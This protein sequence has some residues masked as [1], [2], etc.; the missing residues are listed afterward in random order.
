MGKQAKYL[1]VSDDIKRSFDRLL[2][3]EYDFSLA[4]GK[5]I[6]M[7][8]FFQPLI[9]LTDILNHYGGEQI[10]FKEQIDIHRNIIRSNQHMN[11][12]FSRSMREKL[13]K[14]LTNRNT[15]FSRRASEC[16]VVDC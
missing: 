1:E 16:L 15:V 2:E 3:I 8:I 10:I 5:Y 7:D 14:F 12:V 11:N 13:L 4:K 9:Y 6:W